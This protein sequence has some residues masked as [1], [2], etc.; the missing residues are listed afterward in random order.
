MRLYFI[1]RM[2]GLEDECFVCE[3]QRCRI[4]EV[5]QYAMM[6]VYDAVPS[7]TSSQ[8]PVARSRTILSVIYSRFVFRHIVKFSAGLHSSIA[9]LCG[10]DWRLYSGCRMQFPTEIKCL[11]WIL[12]SVRAHSFDGTNRSVLW[13]RPVSAS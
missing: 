4:I 12:H 1:F 6:Y 9:A 11:H 10:A 2:Y 13:F 8:F 3:F 7:F 5:E